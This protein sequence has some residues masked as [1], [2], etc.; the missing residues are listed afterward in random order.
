MGLILKITFLIK[1]ILYYYFWMYRSRKKKT[2]EWRKKKSNFTI[3]RKKKG[4]A[5]N[6]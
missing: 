1:Q 2:I 3:W 4:G 5:T 6:I